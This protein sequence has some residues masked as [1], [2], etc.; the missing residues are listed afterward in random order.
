MKIGVLCSSKYSLPSLYFL[1]QQGV[2]VSLILPEKRNE[3][4]NEIEAF[5]NQYGLPVQSWSKKKLQEDLVSWSMFSELNYIWVITFPYI[6]SKQTIESLS[7]PIMNFHFAPL[8]NYG[9]VQ[10]VFWM[11]KNGEKQGGISVHFLTED[12]DAGPLVHFEPYEM[13]KEETFGSYLSNMATLNI[14]VIQ[15][16]FANLGQF[17]SMKFKKHE[18]QVKHWGK[19]SLPD[20]LINWS[21][22]SAKEITRLCKAGNPWNKGAVT[23]LN[24]LMVNIIE[25][26][27]YERV[28]HNGEE[29]GTIVLFEDSLM[30]S[31]VDKQYL[32]LDIVFFEG[33]YYSSR[34]LSYIGIVEGM[35]FV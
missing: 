23:S 12:I 15:S 9:G 25:T 35:R 11:I 1:I 16:L 18:A 4:G 8:P 20:V 26:S 7:I 17:D 21:T 28:E 13:K 2:Q 22:M 19:P 5:S 34:S 6:I 27:I 33:S 10:P 3:D 29:F 24:G 32:K 31:S 14:T 30:I